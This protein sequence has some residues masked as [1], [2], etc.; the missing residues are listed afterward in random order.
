MRV[1]KRSV[2]AE[3]NCAAQPASNGAKPRGPDLGMASHPPVNKP[4]PSTTSSSPGCSAPNL[5]SCQ[6][7]HGRPGFLGLFSPRDTSTELLAPSSGL[8]Q[9][10]GSEPADK[11]ISLHHSAFQQINLERN[12]LRD[13]SKCFATK[14]PAF[15][16]GKTSL[17]FFPPKNVFEVQTSFNNFQ[18]IYSAKRILL[19]P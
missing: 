9:P 13:S 18:P 3:G 16:F 10:L 8:A 17:F 6:G 15:E 1:W 19:F 7:R 5:V 14:I 4:N 2:S 11:N 12:E